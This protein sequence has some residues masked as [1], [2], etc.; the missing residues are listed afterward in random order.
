MK[1]PRLPTEGR[2]KNLFSEFEDDITIRVGLFRHYTSTHVRIELIFC[3]SFLTVTLTSND[4]RPVCLWI[5]GFQTFMRQLRTRIL[6]VSLSPSDSQSLH[7]FRKDHNTI[8][9]VGCVCC[10]HMSRVI[11]KCTISVH[12]CSYVFNALFFVTSLSTYGKEFPSRSRHRVA[13]ARKN[14]QP[15]L[16]IKVI[17]RAVWNVTL[18]ISELVNRGYFSTTPVVSTSMFMRLVVYVDSWTIALNASWHR[19]WP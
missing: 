1:L 7:T 18:S 10:L 5:F 19:R 4:Y 9:S 6:E 3:P 15:W 13:R 16:L 12:S 17:Q 11:I 14:R 2:Q 8:G